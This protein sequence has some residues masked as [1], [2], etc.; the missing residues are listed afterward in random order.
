MTSAS[1]GKSGQSRGHSG[2]TRVYSRQHPSPVSQLESVPHSHK[3]KVTV[4]P[5]IELSKHAPPGQIS[6]SPTS[7][8]HTLPIITHAKSFWGLHFIVTSA[9]A[10]K[11]GQGQSLTFKVKSCIALELQKLYIIGPQFPPVEQ[12]VLY[13]HL[14][15]LIGRPLLETISMSTSLIPEVTGKIT[16]ENAFDESQYWIL[17]VTTKPLRHGTPSGIE[18]VRL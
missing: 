9:S 17:A 16:C 12:D 1:A 8:N 15:S 6:Y 14:I 13:S 3:V 11:S 4:S 10:G 7:F 5:A 2:T 18:K